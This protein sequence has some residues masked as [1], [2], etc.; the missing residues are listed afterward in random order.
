MEDT[1][2]RRNMA[3]EGKAAVRR[4]RR[5]NRAIRA[6]SFDRMAT[7]FGES[8][9]VIAFLNTCHPALEAQLFRLATRATRTSVGSKLAQPNE[10][11]A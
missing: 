7:T 1:A 3:F 6:T 2:P 4:L 8:G 5:R 10:S 9:L 11:E